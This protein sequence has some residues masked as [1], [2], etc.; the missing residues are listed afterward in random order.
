MN[1]QQHYRMFKAKKETPCCQ[2]SVRVKTVEPGLQSRKCEL[3]LTVNW[4]VLEKI[5]NSFAEGVLKLR[6]LSDSEAT[7][8]Q[9][10][11]EADLSNLSV[12][13]L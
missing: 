9:E 13:D 8:M 2:Q 10:A 6:W 11:H 5:H 7:A 3:C 12:E 4:F 1:K